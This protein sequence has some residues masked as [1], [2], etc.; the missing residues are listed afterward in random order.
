MCVCVCECVRVCARACVCVCLCV[1]VRVCMLPISSR[2]CTC[3]TGVNAG[4]FPSFDPDPAASAPSD[5][6]DSPK[7]VAERLQI[8]KHKLPICMG[9]GTTQDFNYQNSHICT[10]TFSN[11]YAHIHALRHPHKH[12]TNRAPEEQQ[13]AFLQAYQQLLF[14]QA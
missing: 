13:A 6:R 11:T 7:G 2:A 14:P 4:T 3:H 9:R 8:A 5:G 1:Y 12:H 10:T